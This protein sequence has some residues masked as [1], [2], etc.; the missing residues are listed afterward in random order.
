M[1]RPKTIGKSKNIKSCGMPDNE[2]LGEMTV[3]QRIELGKKH[4]EEGQQVEFAKLKI[5]IMLKERKD[6]SIEQ[7]SK[8]RQELHKE[9]EEKIH[10]KI[11]G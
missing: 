1:E 2:D 3:E 6:L 5:D 11:F 10:N 4:V 8:L 9:A 7:K